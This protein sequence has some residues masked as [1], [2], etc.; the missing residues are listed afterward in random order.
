MLM[1]GWIEKVAMRLGK[2]RDRDGRGNENVR[3]HLTN[4]SALIPAIAGTNLEMGGGS[5]ESRVEVNPG[6]LVVPRINNQTRGQQ[7][8]IF[9][10]YA[11]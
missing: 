5:R 8:P 10:Y 3:R 11:S 4:H 9:I 2:R 1:A 6:Q 7:P